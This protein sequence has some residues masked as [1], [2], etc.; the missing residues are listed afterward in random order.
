M[1]KPIHPSAVGPKVSQIANLFQRKQPIEV[2]NPV[3]VQIPPQKESQ[4]PHQAPTVTVVRTESHS[5]RFN[6]A[7]S[8]FE[9]LSVEN[10]SNNPAALSVKMSRSGSREDNLCSDI[11]YIDRRSPSPAKHRNS[12]PF[13]PGQASLMNNNCPTA[14]SGQING[15]KF[16]EQQSKLH[17]NISRIKSE[18]TSGG[19]GEK[20]EK[21]ERKFNSRELIEKQKKW[22]S[23]FTKTKTNRSHSDPNRCDIIRTG[24]GTA[25]IPG[26]IIQ[27]KD[28]IVMN[29]KNANN[30]NNLSNN[31]VSNMFTGVS[32]SL[33]M[34]L[35]EDMPPSPPVRHAVHPPD[36][37]PRSNVKIGSPIKSP[38]LPPIPSSKPKNISPVKF[39]PERVRSPTKVSE[40]PPPQTNIMTPMTTTPPMATA[41]PTSPPPPP[42]KLVSRSSID[43]IPPELPRKR[44]MDILEDQLQMMSGGLE[45]KRSSVDKDSGMFSPANAIS[46]SPSP[47]PSASSGPSSPVHTEDEKQENESTEKSEYF[48]MPNDNE[49]R[50]LKSSEQSE[51]D[52]ST[53]S[54]Q[55][56][57]VPRI[58]KVSS[59][60]LNLPAAGLGSRPASIISSV[61]TDEG[62]FNEPSPE[63][64]AKLKPA[65]DF[66]PKYIASSIEQHHKPPEEEV[67]KSISSPTAA[68]SNQV[69]YTNNEEEEKPS[70]NYV[71]VGYRLNPDG[72][73][74]REVFGESELYETAKIDL[75]KSFHANGF[76]QET[77]TVYAV[78]KPDV[79]PPAELFYHGEAVVQE[80]TSTSSSSPTQSPPKIPP[81]PLRRRS[82][83]ISGGSSSK[84][85]PPPPPAAFGSGSAS[86]SPTR[87]PPVAAPLETQDEFEIP[88]LP[89]L[90]QRPPPLPEGGPLDMQ[91]IEYADM[92]GGEDNDILEEDDD[93]GDDEGQEV[94][95]VN[96]NRAG[97]SLEMGREDSLPDAM[98]A[99]E[100]ERLLSS[101]QQPLLSDEQAKEVEQILSAPAAA[102]TT[103]VVATPIVVSSHQ[104][105]LVEEERRII[106]EEPEEEP[107]CN[108]YDKV[109]DEDEPEWLR[110][111]LDAPNRSLE[112]SIHSESAS[113]L[114]ID[115]DP[116]QVDL[117][118]TVTA[119][120]VE[121]TYDEEQEINCNTTFDIGSEYNNKHDIFNQT[122]I[123]QE[124]LHDSIVSAESA[125][126]ATNTSLQN[127][128]IDDSVISSKHNSN[129]SLAEQ[130][131]TTTITT[132][133]QLDESQYYIPEYP[134]VRSKEVYVESGVHYFEDGNFWMEVPGLLESDDDDITYPPIAVKKNNKIRFSSGPIQV[135]STFSVT[136]YDRRNEDVDPVAAS[137]E[138]ELEKRV[139]KM[140]V[141]PVELM[142]GPEGLGLSIIGMGVGADAGLEKLGI[143]VKT[144]TDNGAAARD[145]RIQVND[146]IIEVDG[147]SLVGVTQAYAASVLRNTS[148]LVKFQIGRER[149]PENSEV[150]QLIRLSLQADKEKEERLKRQQEEYLRRTL[151]YSEDSTQPASA[152]SSVSEGP[153]SPVQVEHPMEVEATH[154]QEVESLKRLLQ[155]HKALVKLETTGNEDELLNERLRQTERE[156][157]NI[158]K[159]AS[160]LQNMLQQSQSQYMALDKK[161]NKAKRLVR[162][163]QQ[164]EVDMV[165]REEFYQQLLQE[166]DT[167][168][169]ALVKKL[170]DRVI[171][172][173]HELQETQ[174]KAGFPVVLPYD[175][176][177]LKLTPQMVRKAPPKPLFHKLET[178]LSDTEISD[179]SPDGEGVKTATVER[180]VPIK[181]ELDAAVPQHELLDNSATKTK[182][183]LASRGGLANR[184]LPTGKKS[185]SNSSSDCGLDSED[186]LGTN[187]TSS[188][189]TTMVSNGNHQNGHHNL[190]NSTSDKYV[191]EQQIN[192]L[193]AQVHKDHKTHS[194]IPNIFK[195]TSSDSSFGVSKDLNSS[196]DSILGSND[197][198]SENDQTENWMYPSRRRGNKAPPASFTDQLNQV[199]TDRER[200]L[201]D[202]SSRH[203]SDDYTEINKSQSSAALSAKTLINEIRQA[204]N[205]AQPKV[206]NVVPQSL[207]PPGTVPWQ[208]QSQLSHPQGPPSPT[209]MSSGSTSPGYSPSRCMDLSGSSNSFSERKSTHNYKGGPVHEWTKEQVGHWLM[210][211][212]LDR[213]I[214]VFKEHNVEGGALLT[215]DSKD[216]KTLGVSGDDKQRLKRRL[217]DLK[218]SIEK[219]RKDQERERRER[220]KAIRKAEKKAAK[221]K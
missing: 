40:P 159:E 162:E 116:H 97:D 182:I 95:M 150:A 74:S 7:R 144:I 132:T 138:Y 13:P 204:V 166:K 186:D 4:M 71:D 89:A 206:K 53:Q 117:G 12:S 86:T 21:P 170:K 192:Q 61:S 48:C 90:P 220:E 19:G 134:P 113:F 149:D 83:D 67:D 210:G 2:V 129:Y 209:S 82:S 200:R 76:A 197:K 51:N 173:E 183:D 36:I 84:S 196:Y 123:Q 58:K 57:V 142:K 70:L 203:S 151:D 163:F 105:Q 115:N 218:A 109:D 168:Y 160:N 16:I 178:E 112:N 37:K 179:L 25:L 104:H 118:V 17:H 10:N 11:N 212:D 169:N 208:Q 146:Q 171:N 195:T 9:K 127:T 24:P 26:S 119:S 193:Y 60:C 80:I 128:T 215:L 69:Q 126:S 172:L 158:K 198:L 130:E 66:E 135:F 167:E 152:N 65:Y 6:H 165:H 73:E 64:K 30:S 191:R 44:S 219:E 181:D 79:P 124:S 88:E 50:A 3:E 184:Q 216:F 54:V 164:R 202:G 23:H 38:P 28:P 199:L 43:E 190:H 194:T 114:D 189:N 143:F 14:A 96:R 145:G 41:L 108:K 141:F 221:K 137:A 63:I 201:G 122:Y 110:D 35:D 8:L 139:E 59:I 161:Y 15:T 32:K 92:S 33:D 153:T 49:G 102:T 213:Y 101:R 62:G 91:D 175:S 100:A 85:P 211:I 156:L 148:G 42:A 111:V 93:Q 140:H 174:R 120:K 20:P 55:Q 136:D 46:S 157:T 125:D 39:H 147:K 217:K 205:E 131:S 214:P 94:V 72:S 52:L 207:S 47:A 107:K 103:T 180:K 176:T 121:T 78:I 133:T 5:T 185:L 68:D 81:S 27:M 177:T 31:S 1:E 188:T 45:R 75:H 155:E 106:E 99:D 98:T 154:S 77:T 29:N 187:D 34:S 22:T 56:E 87:K 18:E